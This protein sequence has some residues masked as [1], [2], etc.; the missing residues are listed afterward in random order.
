MNCH[1]NQVF[2]MGEKWF[3]NEITRKGG[4]GSDNGG[5]KGS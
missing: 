4:I 1:K 5:Y 2:V 3:Y